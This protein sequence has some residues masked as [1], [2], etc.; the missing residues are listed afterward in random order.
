V[1]VNIPERGISRRRSEKIGVDQERRIMSNAFAKI[2]GAAMSGGG[3]PIKDGNYVM[4]VEKVMINKGHTGELFIAEL[5][6]LEAAANG[7]TDE[8]GRPVVPNAVGSTCSLV[9]NLTKHEA[10]AG[11]AK[12]FVVGAA[13]GLNYTEAQISPEVMGM[14]CGEK[15]PLRGVKVRCSTFRKT[16]QGRANSA[17][18][19]KQLT[20][21]NWE[22]IPQV[23]AD[24]LAAREWLEKNKPSA[25]NS[26]QQAVVQAVAGATPAQQ[27]APAQPAAQATTQKVGGILG[28]ILGS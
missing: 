16:N 22:A 25:D 18:A 17:N 1:G 5:R 11:N 2:S 14:I 23:E 10:A 20:L 7:A 24:V 27:P 19:G 6:V 26:A 13:G 15:N 9:C 28:G 21:C 3:N 8:M 12:K 4:L